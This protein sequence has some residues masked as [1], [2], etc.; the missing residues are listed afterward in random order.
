METAIR[1]TGATAGPLRLKVLAGGRTERREAAVVDLGSNSWRLVVFEYVPGGWW[2]RTG[3]IQE[4]VRIG[5][6]LE[7]TGLLSRAAMRRGLE[8]LEIFGR[9]CAERGIATGSVDVVATSAIRDAENRGEFLALARK[10]TAFEIRVLSA[11]AEAHAAYVAAVNSTT[12]ADGV[13]L[14]LGGGSLQLVGVD[15]RQANRLQ[16]W[17]LGAVRVTERLLPGGDPVSR[18]RL[19]KARARLRR[20]LETAAWT[21][22][23]ATRLVGVGGA[24]RNLAAAAH[25]PGPGIQGAELRLTD[26][27]RLVEE[28]AS[29]PASRRAMPGIKP[30]R[31]DIVLA[32]ALVLEA[33]VEV[34]GFEALE[35]TRAGLRE[36]VFIE[37]RL[38]AGGP[39]L[40]ANV[41]GASVR[42]LASACGADLAHGE[43]VA[44]LAVGLHDS[45]V[46][47]GASKPDATE[48]DLLHAAA[49]L[50][51]IGMA[52]G[53]DGLSEH[54]EYLVRR[55]GL[56]GF[57]PEERE[58]VARIVRHHRKRVPRGDAVVARCALLVRIAEQLDRGH[59]GLVRGAHFEEEGRRLALRLDGETSLA[60]WSLERCV[61]ADAFRR[62]FGRRLTI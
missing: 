34:G 60:R 37:R 26:L 45:L 59:G 2:R 56:P 50:H 46:D 3:Q 55:S 19:A 52:I 20:E 15:G 43:R 58:R 7:S 47:L 12:L 18:K 42:N 25:G 30:A 57:T 33:V 4:P 53:H 39:P 61:S 24:V 51:E 40:L 13:V 1:M 17:P 49:F 14:D 21:A 29:R 31:A 10:A 22:D 16:S 44:R 5:E 8:T 9:Y 27:A 6:G 41:R 62:V 32:A 35:V 23:A 38:L 36:G 54:S 48:R 11:E 28:L